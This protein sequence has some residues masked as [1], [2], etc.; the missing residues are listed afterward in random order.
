MPDIQCESHRN[1]QQASPGLTLVHNPRRL[2]D[3]AEFGPIPE[4]ASLDRPQISEL[5]RQARSP[6]RILAA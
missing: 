1:E 3:S 6:H 5:V 2:M 4:P